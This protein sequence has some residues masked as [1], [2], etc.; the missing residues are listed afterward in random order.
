MAQ[1]NGILFTA[2]VILGPILLAVAIGF[3]VQ[4]TRQRHVGFSRETGPVVA[5]GD[6]AASIG[7]D[8]RSTKRTLIGLGAPVGFAVV[9]IAILFATHM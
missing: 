1:F 2:M 8:P 5:R 4:H 9:V 7:R 6:D 3:G